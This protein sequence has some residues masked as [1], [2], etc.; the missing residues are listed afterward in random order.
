ME[1]QGLILVV[2]ATGSGKSTTTAAMLD[3][4]NAHAPG[5]IVT[6]E[7]PVEFIHTRKQSVISQREVGVDT[8]SYLVALHKALRQA[9]DV[10]F[11]GELRDHETIAVALHAAETGHLVLSTLH[12]TNATGTIERVLNFFPPEARDGMLLQVSLLLRAVI[13]QR[14]V[15]RAEGKGR[16]AAMEI[17]LNTPR[18]QAIIRRGELEMI[19]Q[20]IEEGV[21]EGLQ[22]LDQALRALYQA[23]KITAEDALRFADSPNNMRL[24]IRGIK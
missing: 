13:A 7:D 1:R 19:R 10:I 12:A 8:N 18:L 16:I 21:L 2:G 3:Y 14:L 23:K 15:P 5:H 11:L 20:A 22:T 17:M 24:R 9:P 6:V 4:R